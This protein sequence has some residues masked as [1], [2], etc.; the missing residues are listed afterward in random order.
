MKV[1]QST[2]CLKRLAFTLVFGMSCMALA[3]SGE[4]PP[5]DDSGPASKVTRQESQSEPAKWRVT[6]ESDFPFAS[7]RGGGRAQ[8]GLTRGSRYLSNI[9]LY[10]TGKTDAFEWSSAIGFAGS[11][12][13]RQLAQPVALNTMRLDMRMGRSKLTLGDTFENFSQYS[14]N[15]PVKGASYAFGDSEAP[16]LSFQAVVGIADSRWRMFAR[17][18]AID[19]PRRGATGARVQWRPSDATSVGLSFLRTTDSGRIN[20]FDPLYRNSVWSLTAEHGLA[21]GWMLGA[22]YAW[23]DTRESPDATSADRDY[24]GRALRLELNGVAGRR[25]LQVSYENVSPNFFTSLGSAQTD[26]E[27]IRL[28]IRERLSRNVS[29]SYG[30]I[31]FRN[32]LDN[33][34]SFR[35]TAVR[36]D[37]A[38]SISE[39]AGRP[40]ASLDLTL[41][42]DSRYGGGNRNDDLDFMATYRDVLAGWDTEW[43]IGTARYYSRGSRDSR[44][45]TVNTAW[46]NRVQRGSTVFR[47]SFSLGYWNGRDSV[48]RATDRNL[49]ASF[50]LGVEW[51]NTQTR[52]DFRTGMRRAISG[53]GDDNSRLFGNVMLSHRPKAWQSFGG[54]LFMRLNWNDFRYTTSGRNFSETTFSF[55][56]R[57]EF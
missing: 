49:E 8:S 36:P 15:T 26:R 35:T 56:F 48:A 33:Q 41:S 13:R 46:Y 17:G 42:S 39:F 12:D 34:R 22:E 50:G 30:L 1:N 20:A 11:S 9:S 19:A 55:G 52:L 51:P 31:W 10:G 16:G 25:K 40:D 3:D 24:R 28:R 45:F 6:T 43:N 23:S 14:L 53:L 54:Q 4:G 29:A 27:R 5:A 32:N 2:P 44:E 21:P 37:I 7:A 47:P 38:L 18:E 57:T